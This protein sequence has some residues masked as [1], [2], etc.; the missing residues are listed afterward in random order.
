M[1]QAHQNTPRYTLEELK[2][3]TVTVVGF[4]PRT[5]VALCNF[6]SKH[7]IKHVI[8]DKR[9]C[10]ELEESVAALTSTELSQ[11][12]FSA[13]DFSWLSDSELIITSP[14]V[15][16]QESIFSTATKLGVPVVSEIEFSSWFIG[17][18]MIAVTGTN[19]K[20]TTAYLINQM[21]ENAGQRTFL[22]GN[23]GNPLIEAANKSWDY[24][25]VEVSSFQLETIVHFRPFI[26]ILLNI[27]EDHL[28]RHG[29]MKVYEQ[30]KQRIFANQFPRRMGHRQ[31]R[32]SALR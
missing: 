24:V 16:L 26:A 10:S 27:T 12:Q 7:Q 2:E 20:S 28:D 1:Q 13:T 15:P 8:Y 25:V 6:L 29:T 21:L 23:F 14:G 18:P 31:R 5:G 22:G 9:P 17:A 19:G 32:R 3:K 11:F 4:G 30:I